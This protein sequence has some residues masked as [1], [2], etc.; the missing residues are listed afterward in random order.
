[1]AST[2]LLKDEFVADF[3]AFPVGAVRYLKFSRKS[4]LDCCAI[5][6]TPK[7]P[8]PLPV[9]PPVLDHE[10]SEPASKPNVPSSIMTT[11]T[12]DEGT[13][14]QLAFERAK[15]AARKTRL[16]FKK[17]LDEHIRPLVLLNPKPANFDDMA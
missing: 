4:Y 9:L 8:T 5:V 2:A 13:Q 17:D 10:E 1:M 15:K 7:P 16:R 11:Q 6:A 12:P 3:S 14:I